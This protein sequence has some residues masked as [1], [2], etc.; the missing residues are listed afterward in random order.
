MKNILVGV[1]GGI[2]A[3]KSASIVSLL[4]KKGYNVK[5]VM[6]ENATNIIGPLTLETLSKN[7]VYV[8]MWDKNPHYEV[9]HISLADWADIVLIAPATYNIIGK[10]ANGIAD[11]MLSTIL[12][13]VSLRKPVF[14]ALAMNVNMYENPILNENIDKLKTYGYRFIDTNEGLLACN[15]EAKGR[16]K[17][18]E[19][20]VDI[21]ER[22]NLA[23]KIDNFRDALKGKKL[24]ITS[25]RTREDIDPIRY[26]SNKSSGKMG[27]SLA[28]AAV[29]LGAEVTLVSGPTNLNVPDGLKEFI[30]VDS[31]IHMYEKVDEKFK[32]TDIFIAC[33]AVA[34]YRP[35]EYQDK[36]IKKSDLNLTIELV[37]NPDILFEM[38][39]KKENQLLVGFAAETNNIIE[40]ALKKLE[41]K[42]LDMIVANNAST[43]GTDTNS[44]EI[45]RKDRSSTVINQKSKIELAYDI[46]KEV[47]LDLKKAKDEEK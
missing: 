5:V 12:S 9:E 14:F 17:E 37:R 18:P 24:L 28:Q 36:K 22:Y 27:Y 31:A 38:G 47:I 19:E 6:T 45:I 10:V 23:S 39:K 35:K 1:T 4:K 34:D 13:A 15:Y 26:L 25:G 29:D 42:N 21:I 41:K 46:L 43:M 8:D 40:N 2:A 32:D 30:S 3:F 20:I 11:D 44:I 33:A 16:M 7:R